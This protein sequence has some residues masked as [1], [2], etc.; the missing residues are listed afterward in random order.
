[1]NIS[2]EISMYPL[3]ESYGNLI[4]DFIERLKQYPEIKVESNRMSTQ[5]FGPFDEV[6]NIVNKEMKVS[7]QE[8]KTIVTVLKVVNMA[9]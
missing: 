9:V 8:D 2:L 6:M 7:F 3:D 5:V 1:M 4:I